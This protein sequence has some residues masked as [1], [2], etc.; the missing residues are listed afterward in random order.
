MV[1]CD[2]SCKIIKG[3]NIYDILKK[4]PNMTIL[5]NLI[6]LAGLAETISNLVCDTMF[7]PNNEAFA[8][9]PKKLIEYLISVEGR[10]DLI[11]FIYYHITTGRMNRTTCALYNKQILLMFNFQ[12]TMIR[13]K[14]CADL[15]IE[16]NFGNCGVIYSGNNCSAAKACCI[17]Q[18][19]NAVLI[20]Y[21]PINPRCIDLCKCLC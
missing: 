10:S 4:D 18:K 19:I 5:V 20:P 7:A 1:T 2:C 6:D 13:K 21:N 12:T 9:L 3:K 17:V 8:K 15:C 16:D 14:D 11:N